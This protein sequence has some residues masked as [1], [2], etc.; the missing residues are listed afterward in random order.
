M[1]RPILITSA[2][3]RSRRSLYTSTGLGAR[4]SAFRSVLF[5]LSLALI[6]L[7]AAL[8][9]DSDW[10]EFLSA[11]RAR[12]Y[13]DVAL[14]YMT[15]LQESGDA[16]PE[17]NAELDYKIGVAA[18]E[19]S[20]GAT[21]AKRL[22]LYDRAATA[23]EKYLESSPTGASS[24]DANSRLGRILEDRGDRLLRESA[25]SGLSETSRNEK[26]TLARAAFG[27]AR[28]RYDAGLKL[29]R[30][31][32]QELRGDASS[33]PTQLQSVQAQF[34]DMTIRYTTVGAQIGR[35]Y[36][37]DSSEYRDSLTKAADEYAKIYSTYQQYPGA[38]RAHFSEAEIRRE[39]GDT[40][41][42]LKLLSELA[43][44]P[45]SE[46]F[47]SL[48]T[49][50]LLL[51]AEI[52]IE[53]NDPELLM[54]LLQK[55]ERWSNVEKLPQQYYS[56]AEG[57]KIY[58]LV[59]QGTLALEKLRRSDFDAYSAAGKRTFVDTDDPTFR[60][61]N[62]PKSKKKGS[63]A[64]LIYAAKALSFVAK[65]RDA[66]AAAAQNI[67]QTDELF[68]DVDLSKLSFAERADDF[69]SAANIASRAATTFSQASQN[70]ET[71]ASDVKEDAKRERD[72]AAA[73]AMEALESAFDLSGRALRPDR[74]GKLSAEDA[75]ATAAELSKLRLKYAIVALAIGR[76]EDAFAV[77]DELARDANSADAAQGALV[78][79]RATQA[80]AR[81]ISSGEIEGNANYEEASK[82]YAEFVAERWG[83]SPDSPLAEEA[84]SSRLDAA[85]DAEDFAG[86]R[87]ALSQIPSGSSRRA[88]AELKL[89]RALW[90][91][92]TSRK[93]GD[94]ADGDEE[95]G[96]DAELAQLLTESIDLLRAG[97]TTK[98]ASGSTD[99]QFAIYSSYVLGQAYAQQGDMANAEKYLTH[100][101]LGAFTVVNRVLE[102]ENG[103]EPYEA[104]AIAN[105][106]FQMAVLALKLRIATTSGEDRLEEARDLATKLESVASRS[107][108]NANKLSILFLSL[109]KRF[110]ERLREL[111]LAADSGDATKQE[112]F[113]RVMT[114][115]K[116][117]LDDASKRSEGGGYASLRWLADSYLSLGRGL[118]DAKGV[119]T[120]E[121]K[122]YV[123][124]AR[125]AYMALAKACATP[126]F[127][128]PENAQTSALLKT[129]E[130]DRE[131]GSYERAYSSVQKILKKAPDSF[132]AQREA[133]L[134]L[135][136]WGKI[137]PQNYVKAIAGDVPNAR[138]TKLVWGWNGMI[139]RLAP[140]INKNET[141]KSLYFESYVGKT[142]S[143]YRYVKSAPSDDERKKRALEA[144][145]DLKRLYQTNPTMGGAKSFA[146]FDK[147]YREFQK[148]RGESK[149][150]GLS[151]KK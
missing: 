44:L 10:N 69:E 106:S 96:D 74:R 93:D 13:D 46:E 43:V 7:G 108:E 97:L 84:A 129:C 116:A 102:S 38:F 63:N 90:N 98:F 100:P 60:L 64:V 79:L 128:A 110:E 147:A 62:V 82:A 49:R 18:T 92:W 115:F 12:G 33:S 26:L 131:S 57:R 76:Y 151:G 134:I 139:K 2:R 78:A 39:L 88:N 54:S 86:A 117:F 25:A 20:R 141:M 3:S 136:E 101:K 125:A 133:A 17:L 58:L 121:G 42:A 126:G 21:G 112:E 59:G 68:A 142:R 29:A 138:G 8:G 123:T 130:C 67:L 145:N 30:D 5:L 34:L 41:E 122:E 16:P 132:D 114:S 127:S 120:K 143:R 81:S 99:D 111:K 105:D 119:M 14:A 56:S 95:S 24:V 61:L 11:L 53:R 150:V 52:A 66:D 45:F 9:A 71:A 32:A 15:K 113:D 23:F 149:P 135:H 104:P 107:P 40:K 6:P 73:T 103:G 36:P 65:G 50:A 144:E 124:K 137:D 37:S 51:F 47:Y 27:D 4:A 91:E 87:E 48:K 1:Q 28:A 89:G 80:L 31:V 19:E 22:E 72:A 118:V 55:F 85:L 109:G 70:Y 148:L 75:E 94:E 77:G 140:S 83:D 146:Y 35:T